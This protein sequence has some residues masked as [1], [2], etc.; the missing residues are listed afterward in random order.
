MFQRTKLTAEITQELMEALTEGGKRDLRQ[1]RIDDLESEVCELVDE[2]TRRTIRGVA[3]DQAVAC[4]EDMRDC[5]QCGR[6]LS[7]RPPTETTLV[8]QRGEIA[9]EQPVKRCESCRCDFF[10]S[11]ES[12]GD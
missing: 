1:L 4:G 5:P 12:D 9:W 3:E 8:T 10:P 6:E 2:I 11:G 7:D